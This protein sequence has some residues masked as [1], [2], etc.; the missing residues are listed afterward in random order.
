MKATKTVLAKT[1][2]L[3][4]KKV[5]SFLYQILASIKQKT[6]VSIEYDFINKLWLHKINGFVYLVDLQASYSASLEKYNLHVNKTFL[7]YYSIKSDDT[8]IDIGAGVGTE[9]VVFQ[10][11]L[12]SEGRVYAIEAHPLTYN[13]LNILCKKNNYKNVICTNMA[14]SDKKGSVFI[15]SRDNHS[16]NS[17][18]SVQK[19]VQVTAKT[20]EG[21][22]DEYNIQEINF[23]KI[24]IEGA[25][26]LVLSGL[27]NSWYKIKHIA[28]A[29]H[30]NL[31]N[32]YDNQFFAT[33][34]FVI[35]TLKKNNFEIEDILCKSV[36]IWVYAKNRNI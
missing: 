15:E 35:E 23:L 30:D 7:K 10:K 22:I 3:F 21:F 13:C 28:V 11:K 19:G 33:K 24:N 34:E 32:I 12:S 5:A 4:G 14:V 27:N 18:L 29:C 9:V 17:I 1:E 6:R 36:D 20:L 2:Y 31:V 16:A 26:R 25:E 8:I